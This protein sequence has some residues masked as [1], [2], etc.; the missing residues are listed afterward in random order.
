[1]LAY[2]LLLYFSARIPPIYSLQNHMTKNNIIKIIWAVILVLVIVIAICTRG[3]AS[4]I[5]P[6]SKKIAE[7]SYNIN[8]L[9]SHKNICL[10]NLPYRESIENENGIHTYCNMYDELIMAYQEELDK[11]KE[12]RPESETETAWTA[13]I[14]ENREPWM[15]SWD[16]QVMPEIQATT[17]HEKFK[18]MAAAYWLDASKIRTVENRYGIKEWVILC[19]TVAE[20]SGWHRGYW[21]GNIWNVGNNDR[22]D[23]VTF[24]FLETWLEKIWQTLNNR[25]LGSIQT[26]GCLSNGGSC[27][28]RDNNSHRYA[29]S[30]GNWE[31]NMVACLS[32]IYGTVD[33]K[34][35]SVRR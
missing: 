10:D 26:L 15:V 18:E 29:T 32:K 21:Q 11:L 24:A 25:Y 3:T 8:E 19:I 22:G 17:E 33:A 34:T 7:L 5:N 12:W 23:R 28:A 30:N 1:M 6:N 4:A 27:Q 2:F 35:F 16:H 13:E 20:T 9:E 31:R 14:Q